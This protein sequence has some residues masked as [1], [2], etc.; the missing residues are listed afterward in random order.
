MRQL[1]FGDLAGLVR[2]GVRPLGH[3]G[4]AGDGGHRR[5]VRFESGDVDQC[6]R[7]VEVADGSSAPVGHLAARSR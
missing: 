3:P 4:L 2:L 5:Q 7:R 1:A 6:D